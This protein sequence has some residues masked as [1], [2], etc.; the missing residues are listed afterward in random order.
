[1]KA[2]DLSDYEVELI[3]SMAKD[4]LLD[5]KGWNPTRS[6]IQTVLDVI[7]AKGFDIVKNPEREPTFNGQKQSWYSPKDPKKPWQF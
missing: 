4:R 5:E 3:R 7:H 2:S 6:L 1:M